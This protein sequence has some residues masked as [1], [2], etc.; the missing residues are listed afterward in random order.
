MNFNRS[1]NEKKG[2]TFKCDS[3]DEV[4]PNQMK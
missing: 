3:T 1:G 4:T 2:V